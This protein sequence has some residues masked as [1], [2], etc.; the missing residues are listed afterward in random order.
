M[1]TINVLSQIIGQPDECCTFRIETLY[2][3]VRKCVYF[4]ELKPMATNQPNNDRSS[5]FPKLPTGIQGLDE[6]TGGGSPPRRPAHARLR[7]VRGMW[8]NDA[9]YGISGARGD[10]V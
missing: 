1:S 3:R 4:F 6:I 7:V 10:A 5:T 2:S 8:K 9:R